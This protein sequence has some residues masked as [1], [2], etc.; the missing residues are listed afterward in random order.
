MQCGAING[1]EERI[2]CLCDT[3]LSKNQDATPVAAR[4]ELQTVG[5]LGVELDWRSEVAQRLDAYCVRHG[6]PRQRRIQPELT[7]APPSSPPP[8]AAQPEPPPQPSV[9]THTFEAAPAV[10]ARRRFRPKRIE[11]LEI[12]VQQPAFDFAGAESSDAPKPR[13]S[14]YDSPALPVAS[15]VERRRAGALDLAV[16]FFAYATFWMLFRAFGGRFT[17]SRIDALVDIATLG[18][19]YAQ[20][21]TLFTYFAGATPGMMLRGLRV[22]SLDGLEPSQRQLLWRSFGYLVSAGTMMLG[23]V[24]A[25]WDEDR[26]SWHDRISQ[27][28]VTTDATLAGA[29]CNQ[30]ST[31]Q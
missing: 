13:F 7:F 19:L 9:D 1:A 14:S 22:A 21:V 29:P 12:D 3:R 20:Y 16:V 17:F 10:I 8:S 25:L 28:C 24:W 2:C 26:L 4:A 23:F 11:R 15:L 6:R 27:T 5:D 31:T 18:L 30:P